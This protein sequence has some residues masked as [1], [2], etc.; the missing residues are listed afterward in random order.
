MKKRNNKIMPSFNHAVIFLISSI[1]FID[2]SVLAQIS[3]ISTISQTNITTTNFYINWQTNIAGSSN[4]KYG[5]TPDLELGDINLGDSVSSHSVNLD[6]LTPASFYYILAYS[7]SGADTVFS[8]AGLYST[9]SNSTGIIHAYFNHSI[10]T[11]VSTGINAATIILED[12]IIS[13]I[14]KAQYTLD[15][16]IYNSNNYSIVTAINNAYSQGVTVRYIADLGVTNYALD[17][18]NVSIPLFKGNNSATMHNKFIIIDGNSVNNSWVLAGSVNHTITNMVNDF[19]NIIILQDQALAKAYTQEFNEMWGD[20]STT[21]DSLLSKFGNDKT[22]NIPHKFM[23]DGKVVELYFSPSDNTTIAIYDALA[24]VDNDLQFAVYYFT[25]DILKLGVRDAHNRTGGNVK[26]IMENKNNIGSVYYY[27]LGEGVNIIDHPLPGLLHHKYAIIDANDINSDPI[28]V[29]GSHNW[30]NSAESVNDENTLIIHDATI[31]NIYFQ[32]FTARYCELAPCP[33][34]AAT[35][36]NAAGSSFVIYPNSNRGQFLVKY[37]S[38]DHLPVDIKI[39]DI[40]G[41]VVF[42]KKYGVMNE[43]NYLNINITDFPDGLY[44][45]SINNITKKFILLK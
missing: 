17:S 25:N 5:L 28:V 15:I 42:N 2:H 22:D 23:V 30:T 38:E 41:K 44:L 19:N 33:V 43:I 9:A 24:S 6:S 4:I 14:N 18:L 32:E 12:T 8:F 35:N 45:I 11:S 36:R 21:P 39:S 26:G 10:D 40:A 13:Y 20:T 16:C 7:V 34:L 1:L 29:T 31:A 27:L 37:Y 3:I